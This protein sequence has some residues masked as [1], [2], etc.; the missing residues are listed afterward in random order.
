MLPAAIFVSR[1]KPLRVVMESVKSPEERHQELISVW[2]NVT[3]L[4]KLFHVRG[5]YLR[6]VEA[7]NVVHVRIGGSEGWTLLEFGHASKQG[8]GIDKTTLNPRA[9]PPEVRPSLDLHMCT[10]FYRQN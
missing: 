4:L 3:K 9:V 6:H 8:K 10:R 1:A 2:T 5:W 7:E